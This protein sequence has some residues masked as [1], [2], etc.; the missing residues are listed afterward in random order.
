[1]ALGVS[2][3]KYK[4]PHDEMGMDVKLDS[5]KLENDP[6]AQNLLRE[7]GKTMTPG[8]DYS[9]LGSCAIHWYKTGDRVVLS[10]MGDSLPSH[11]MAVKHQF[12]VGDISSAAVNTGVGQFLIE[13]KK[14]FGYDHK[15]TDT[16]DKRGVDS[17][18]KELK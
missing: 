17:T 16:K 6:W 14:Y 15:T 1:M 10:P 18:D 2:G 3:Q 4:R 11:T 8:P 7:V 13:L 9:Y 5:K 12:A